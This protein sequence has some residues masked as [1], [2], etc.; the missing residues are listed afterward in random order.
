MVSYSTIKNK[1]KIEV[2]RENNIGMAHLTHY[3]QNHI[4]GVS[5]HY[6]EPATKYLKKISDDLNFVEEPQ[7][8]QLLPMQFDVP[9]PPPT[10]YDFTFIDLF[11][12]IGGF[13]IPTQEM[14]GKCVFTSEFNYHA[15]RAY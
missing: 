14:N 1:L 3:F 9:F 2:E 5:Q 8:Q 6:F 13:R 11:A 7:M 10:N 4:N 12:G 15:Q